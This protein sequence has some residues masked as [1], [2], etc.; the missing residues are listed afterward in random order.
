[1]TA[2]SARP[3]AILALLLSGCTVLDTRDEIRIEPEGT[4]YTDWDLA[5][6]VKGPFERFR[7]TVDGKEVEGTFPTGQ[8]V[9][10]P[11]W[12]VADSGRHTLEVRA[13]DTALPL[14]AT[15]IL[16][17][18]RAPLEVSVTPAEREIA[19]GEPPVIEATFSA[20]IAPPPATSVTVT[21][22]S[23]L[24]PAA[25]ELL[26]GERKLRIALPAPLDLGPVSVSV[27][28]KDL[29]GFTWTFD[30]GTWSAPTLALAF[31]SPAA[32][33][34]TNGAVG[35]AVRG[36]GSALP[37]PLEVYAGSLRIA[38]F[39][40][41]PW[42]L[43]W[44]TR[45]VAEGVHP[46][47]LRVRGRHVPGPFPSVTVDRTAPTAACAPA[48]SAMDD[49]WVGECVTVE[50]SEPLPG[51]VPSL[52]VNGVSRSVTVRPL[53]ALEP[54]ELARRLTLCPTDAAPTIPAVVT[55]ALPPD[56]A[57]N[58]APGAA[59]TL[60]LPAWRA[61]WGKGPTVIAGSTLH[62]TQVAF[63][64]AV[65]FHGGFG[66]TKARLLWPRANDSIAGAI[67][68]TTD[69]PYTTG[70][71]MTTD[72]SGPVTGLRLAV[73][74]AVWSDDRG[75]CEATFHDGG[76]LASRWP[77]GRWSP[78]LSGNALFLA[79]SVT[80][81]SGGRVLETRFKDPPWS[82]WS[83]AGRPET[84]P[85][86]VA[87]HPA[88]SW[89]APAPPLLAWLE[90]PANGGPAQLRAAL[91]DLATGIWTS[92]G[93]SLS[94]DPALPASEPAVYA[95]GAQRAVAW[96]EGGRVLVRRWDGAAF[97]A[98]E[99]LTSPGATGRTPRFVADASDRPVVVFVET[100][101]A[102]DHVRARRLDGAGWAPLPDPFGDLTG[103]VA[104]LVVT[105]R[106]GV[107]WLDSAGEV[108]LR[109]YNR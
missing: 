22:G 105:E 39:A 27:A 31:E 67:S 55:V 15:R 29:R 40:A 98:P 78:A 107:A 83:A 26:P 9:R 11:V 101:G 89:S 103:S 54:L 4:L 108:R 5:L 63:D 86:A 50:L 94:A 72:A 87:D 102:G 30:L 65:T 18:D 20:Q 99:A 76:D 104:Q 43:S 106:G 53:N 28:A 8:R 64:A 10:V 82:F 73:E 52:L 14:R 23:E 97:G 33:L 85:A 48:Y 84:D 51:G 37:A 2:R 34:A 66:G 16:V 88:V 32:D 21:R 24:L 19:S 75:M 57:G 70:I 71:S 58:V 91:G 100:D 12:E 7:V 46:L 38:T 56:L 59:C 47:S 93:A 80:T 96:V 77:A 68:G 69:W 62:A 36:D 79:V 3:L 45:G 49:L 92:L 13:I 25:V 60:D 6:T 109:V 17:I 41:P 61:P 74:S 81:P 95:V 44:D 35:I 1:M 42:Q 90:T